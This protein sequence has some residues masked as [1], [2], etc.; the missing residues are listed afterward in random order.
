LKNYT[1]IQT[2]NEVALKA[3]VYRQPVAIGIAAAGQ[4]MSYSSGIFD[5][6]CPGGRDH[7]VLIV[8]YGTE[9]GKD[10]WILKNSWNTGWGEKGYM[11]IA[12]GLTADGLCLL[13][14]DPSVPYIV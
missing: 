13:A 12:R 5:G 9:N 7:A 6:T 2:S 11:R 4:F 3:A 14:T 1:R 10:F 8:G